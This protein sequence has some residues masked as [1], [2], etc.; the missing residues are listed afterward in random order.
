MHHPSEDHIDPVIWILCC[1]KPSPRKR[2]MFTKNNHLNI[3]GYTDADPHQAILPWY[4]RGNL[5]T[6]RNKKQVV[7][8]SNAQRNV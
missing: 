1:L 7:E 5:V 8:L 3:Y 6:W 4:I 2:I